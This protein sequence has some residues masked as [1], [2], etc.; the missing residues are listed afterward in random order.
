M[1]RFSCTKG[2]YFQV[3]ENIEKLMKVNKFLNIIFEK[4]KINRCF[5]KT[6]INK[7]DISFGFIYVFMNVHIKLFILVFRLFIYCFRFYEIFNLFL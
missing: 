6:K 3:F 1:P 7:L 4:L 2:F 5:Q